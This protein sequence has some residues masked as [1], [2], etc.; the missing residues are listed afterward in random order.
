MHVHLE[1]QE[2]PGPSCPHRLFAAARCMF[3][4]AA[5]PAQMVGLQLR[6]SFLGPTILSSLFY[7][8]GFGTP[9]RRELI[10]NA[11]LLLTG[12]VAFSTAA[13]GAR[14]D[15]DPPVIA[16]SDANAGKVC[17][18]SSFPYSKNRSKQCCPGLKCIV[19]L[20]CRC[21]S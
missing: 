14:A 11:P 1:H 20:F 3:R 18:Q 16:S 2:A 5:P 8:V 12:I 4:P 7:N 19:N 17:D 9:S 15:D 13:V 21:W 10:F 6:C